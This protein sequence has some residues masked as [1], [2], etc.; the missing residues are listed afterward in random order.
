MK[1]WELYEYVIPSRET[2]IAH[3]KPVLV[4]CGKLTG[5]YGESQNSLKS[6]TTPGEHETI[7]SNDFGNNGKADNLSSRDDLKKRLASW[8]QTYCQLTRNF[9]VISGTKGL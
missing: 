7:K 1:K 9:L 8:D 3:I 5:E 6:T 4:C 2:N